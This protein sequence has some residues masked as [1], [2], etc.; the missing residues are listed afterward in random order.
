MFAVTPCPRLA[1]DQ[2]RNTLRKLIDIKASTRSAAH[3]GGNIRRR[4]QP[5]SAAELAFLALVIGTFAVFAV[6]MIWLRAD[7]VTFRR[8]QPSTSEQLQ[9][10]AAE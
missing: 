5:M 10:W 6:A 2:P 4:V 7:Y 1:R 9:A 3:E 8:R